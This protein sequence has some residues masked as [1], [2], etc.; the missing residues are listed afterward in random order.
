M[1]LLAVVCMAVV[2][3]TVL[4][5][6]AA[7]EARKTLADALCRYTR[8]DAVACVLRNIDTN[9]DARVT[10]AEIDAFRAKALW[11]YERALAWVARETDEKI[12]SRCDVNGDGV[13]DM[14]DFARNEH[15]C[16]RHCGDR[17]RFMN[18]CTRLD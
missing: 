8:Q 14:F 7:D 6:D 17:V 4:G 11:F 1:S 10:V 2:L 3:S 5:D 15:T 12:M 9:R 18:L 16:M 13:V